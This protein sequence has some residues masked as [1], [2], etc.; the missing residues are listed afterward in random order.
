MRPRVN[1]MLES[2]GGLTLT[3]V[4]SEA[5]GE[6][7]YELDEESRLVVEAADGE[8]AVRTIY[9]G[10]GAPSHRHTYVKLTDDGPIYHAREMLR[11]KFEKEVD[12]LRDKQVLEINDD[13]SEITLTEGGETIHLV[14]SEASASEEA[15]GTEGGRRRRSRCRRGGV[16]HGRRK[17]CQ[18]GQGRPDHQ[19]PFRPEM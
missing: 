15:A 14:R 8:Q 18:E 3:A 2:I 6:G 7:I 10:K 19:D 1:G 16:A 17:R 5:G 4:A 11:S 13:I 12:Q 9:V